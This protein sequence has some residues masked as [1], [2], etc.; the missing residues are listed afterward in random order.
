[1]D[2]PPNRYPYF[3]DR[4]VGSFANVP[5]NVF[6]EGVDAGRQWGHDEM[7]TAWRERVE[8]LYEG[9]YPDFGDD[10]TGLLDWFVAQL[11]K[12]RTE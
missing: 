2:R 4:I 7:G 3:A 5:H 8:A 9:P 1:M 11:L 6:E 12:E 10:K